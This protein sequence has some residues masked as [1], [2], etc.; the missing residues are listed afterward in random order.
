MCRIAKGEQSEVAEGENLPWE[1]EW[2]VEVPRQEGAL[3][4][5]FD[6]METEAMGDRSFLIYIR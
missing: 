5:G 6:W 1:E 2:G 3:R 4:T